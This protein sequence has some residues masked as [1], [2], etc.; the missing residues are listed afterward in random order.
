[1]DDLDVDKLKTV[2]GDRKKI[3]HLVDNKFVQKTK[4]NPLKTK[5]NKIDNNTDKK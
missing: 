2:P 1:M 5:V 4:F 3:R